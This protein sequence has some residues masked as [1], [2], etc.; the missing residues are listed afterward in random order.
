MSRPPAIEIVHLTKWF[1]GV[2]ALADVGFELAT[3]EVH[4]VCGENGAGKSTLIKVL[5]GIHPHGSFEGTVRVAGRPASFRS[6][7][8]A[9]K[10]G[11]AVIHQELSLVPELTVAENLFLGAQPTR[12]GFVEWAG[13]EAQALTLL[14]LFNLDVSPSA[15]VAALGI[16]EQQLVEVLKALAKEAR[17]LLLD[18]PTAALSAVETEALLETVRELRR[19]GISCI[20]ISHRLEDVFAIADRITVLRDGRSVFTSRA[21]Q[22]DR[23]EVIHHMVG[24]SIEERAP[25]S[26][27]ALGEPLLQVSGLTVT[28][29]GTPGLEL[30]GID[31]ELRAGEVLGL[32]GI[33]GAGRTELLLH[34]FAGTGIRVSGSVTLAGHELVGNGPAESMRLGMA[35]V[36]EDRKRTGLIFGQD[37]GFNL[38]LAALGRFLRG[39]LINGETELVEIEAGVRRLGI[40]AP[41]L[42]APVSV[43]SGGNQ[44]KVVLGKA[45]MTEPRVLL[46][47]EPTRGVDVGAKAEIYQLISELAAAGKGVLVASSELPELLAVCDRILVLSDGK[48]G[49]DFVAAAATQERLMSAALAHL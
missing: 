29:T 34:L 21:A 12:G 27:A 36:S 43:L 38:S 20:F 16:G 6:P 37:V 26:T 49:A 8:E 33:M 23:A 13:M 28:D 1:P 17:I 31:F 41:S 32:G 35:L 19:R 30:E 4:A 10:S 22:T 46:L 18:E 2:V 11:I 3:G 25:R 14:E 48:P 5:S 7:A 45:L 15:R 40:R 24:R 42:T 44:Q 39:G 9:E 47:D